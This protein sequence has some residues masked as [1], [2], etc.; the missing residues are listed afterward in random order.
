MA[1]A[2]SGASLELLALHTTTLEAA[3]AAVA[4]GGLGRFAPE[5]TASASW[6]PVALLRHHACPVLC[7]VHCKLETGGRERHLLLSGS[8][9][10]CVALWDLTPLVAA[11]QSSGAED[12]WAPPQLAP[13][14]ALPSVHQSGVNAVA[15]APL[16]PASGG[17]SGQ[18]GPASVLLF[19][20]GDDQA[21]CFVRLEVE[22]SSGGCSSRG[23]GSGSSNGEDAAA[24]VGSSDR[25]HCRVAWSVPL[26]NAHSSAVRGVW[27]DGMA[28]FSVGLDQRVR[29]W[30]LS[31]SDASGRAV[32]EI[33][34]TGCAVT[35]ALEPS[36]LDA[37]PYG[38]GGY[39]VAVAGHCGT[40][41]LHLNRL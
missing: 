34:E 3:A 15:A 5:R 23:P 37:L 41:L 16:Q 30:K 1:V 33:T 11:Y 18:G 39:A 9:D 14:L 7:T 20:G 8:T 38:S 4:A 32:A 19:T 29:C 10:G 22:A 12:G 17:S 40:E 26:P 25:L 27:T 28:S 36:A 21:L 2:S 6:R 24:I 13:L 35:Q 31:G